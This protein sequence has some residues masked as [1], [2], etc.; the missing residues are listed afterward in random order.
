[1]EGK[2]KSP[3]L[4]GPWGGA[5]GSAWDDGVFTAIRQLV[6]YHGAAIDSIQVEYDRKGSSVWGEKHGGQGGA[7]VDKVR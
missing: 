1:M 5:G 2:D 7:R 6:V 4:V 3:I